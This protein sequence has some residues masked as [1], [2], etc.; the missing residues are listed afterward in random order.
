MSAAHGALSWSI[1]SMKAEG[2]TGWVNFTDLPSVEVPED[3]GVY[4]VAHPAPTTVEFLTASSAAFRGGRD[5][6]VPVAR[7]QERWVVGTPI[8][9]IGKASGRAGLR[10][11]LLE[12]R[13]HGLDN[14]AGHWGGRYIWQLAEPSGLLVGW[15]P[16]ASGEDAEDVESALLA[17]FVADHGRLPF[18][19]LKKG[20]RV[21]SS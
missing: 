13:R 1:A 14:R 16:C 3:P 17:R 5:P 19:N 20:R 4:V 2:F 8:V 9:Y 11:R 18:A 6:V 10:Q 15:K 7:L 21:R 12:Y